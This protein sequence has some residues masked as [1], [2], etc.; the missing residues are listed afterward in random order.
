M[1]QTPISRTTWSNSNNLTFCSIQVMPFDH[2]NFGGSSQGWIVGIPSVP[3]DESI[4]PLGHWWK[5]LC[6]WGKRCPLRVISV[7]LVRQRWLYSFKVSPWPNLA[8]GE[9]GRNV[10]HESCLV[11][12]CSVISCYGN[13][14]AQPMGS[15]FLQ[16]ASN[17]APLCTA[18]KFAY[19]VNL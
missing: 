19:F 13:H 1:S 7:W 5:W 3:A 9:W 16:W 14:S 12:S 6:D 17:L 8:S 11:G 18:N 4:Q 2:G 15:E 10:S